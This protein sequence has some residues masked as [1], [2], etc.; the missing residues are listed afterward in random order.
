MRLIWES[1][2]CLLGRDA[3]A[4]RPDQ[5]VATARQGRSAVLAVRGKAGVGK[6]ALLDHAQAAAVDLQPPCHPVETAFEQVAE[7]D[8][9]RTRRR[10]GAP[11]TGFE[12]RGDH[13]VP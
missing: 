12:D 7:A 3:E 13:Q 10:R 8:G 5:I 4:R 2:N 11:S 6:T 1:V 9:N